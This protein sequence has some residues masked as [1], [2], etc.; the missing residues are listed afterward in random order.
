MQYIV[1]TAPCN[2]SFVGNVS[3]QELIKLYSECIGLITT[4][5]DE[6]FGITPLEAMASGK[7]VVATKEGGYL[8]TV[9]DGYTGILISPCVDE[10]IDAVSKISQSP[11]KYKNACII[12]ANK[13]DYFIFKNNIKKMV[14][15]C[16]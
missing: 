4:A 9:I 15:K 8:E 2:V 3:E 13:F 6:D 5:I 12:Q 10:I 14:S 7:P 1:D 11:D 16:Q